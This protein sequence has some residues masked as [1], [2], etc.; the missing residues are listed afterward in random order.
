MAREH[1]IAVTCDVCGASSSMDEISVLTLESRSF[2]SRKDLCLQC[3]DTFLAFFTAEKEVIVPKF[4]NETV[5][6]ILK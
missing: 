3:L 4:F 1:T 2:I 6:A 5:L